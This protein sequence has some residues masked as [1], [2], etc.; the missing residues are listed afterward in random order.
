MPDS[1]LDALAKLY[2]GSAE[3]IL[4][5]PAYTVAWFESLLEERR[6]HIVDR[7]AVE[8]CYN[9]FAGG[10]YT[11]KFSFCENCGWDKTWSHEACDFE[12]TDKTVND[13]ISFSNIPSGFEHIEQFKSII[14]FDNKLGGKN[15]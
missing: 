8:R 10:Y 3:E 13:L 6:M 9:G 2:D 5:M 14:D 12:F 4:N 15:E 11:E 1:R 7:I